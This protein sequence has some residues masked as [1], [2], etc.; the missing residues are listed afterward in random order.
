VR[1]IPACSTAAAALSLTSLLARPLVH[2][3]GVCLIARLP[4]ACLHACV[5]CCSTA[6]LR[7]LLICPC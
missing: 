4:A 6:V 2:A 3:F 1:P 7:P 5:P